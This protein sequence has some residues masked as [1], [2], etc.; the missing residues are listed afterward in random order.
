LLYVSRLKISNANDC[1][2]TAAAVAVA[3]VL[4]EVGYNAMDRG[5]QNRNSG[6]LHI[7]GTADGGKRT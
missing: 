3:A 5:E 4:S 1:R 6:R 7:H 2:A